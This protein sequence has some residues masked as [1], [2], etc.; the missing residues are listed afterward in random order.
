MSRLR[1]LGLGWSLV[2]ALGLVALASACS[3]TSP[4]FSNGGGGNAN[5]GGNNGGQGQGGID[6]IG[7]DGQGGGGFTPPNCNNTPDMDGDGDGWTGA[8]G[9]CNDCTNLM[10]PG[11]YDYKGNGIDEDCNGAA[12]DEEETC[13]TGL[14]IDSNSG[15]DGARAMELC[16]L[17]DGNTWGVQTANFVRSDKLTQLVGDEA[18]G[19]GILSGFGA[20]NVQ[21]G[22]SFLVLSSGAAR[23]PNDPGFQ[24]PGGFQ[25]DQDGCFF[26][27]PQSLPP[28]YSP[29]EP[30]ACPGAS[31]NEV[32]DSA[33]L[34]LSVKTP[35]NAKSLSFK[36]NFYTYEFP[37]YVCSQYNDLYATLMTPKP[38][39]LPDQNISFDTQGN[40]LSVNAGFLEVCSPQSAGGKNFPCALG[41]DLL[42]GTGFETH[43]ATGWLQTTAPVTGGQTIELFMVTW[44]AGDCVLDSTTLLDDF[45]WSLEETPTETAP[46]PVPN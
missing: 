23:D 18:L 41:T 8:Q 4:T 45:Q 34:L 27:G 33:G 43:A 5:G 14:A 11:A 21:K 22:S 13:D 25:K 10:N 44:D 32:Y 46:V 28:G 1:S 35:T 37:V 39:S 38:S 40:V 12:D 7:G 16:K 20:A 3:A 42:N 29:P 9:D 24:D 19:H 36:L 2:P 31:G 30:S 26:G 6:L 15:V 17:S